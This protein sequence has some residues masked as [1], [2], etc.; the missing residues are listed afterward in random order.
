M[1]KKVLGKWA[2]MAC[3]MLMVTSCQSDSL[4]HL[5]TNKTQAAQ[6]YNVSGTE[7][8]GNPEG[9]VTLVVISSYECHYCRKDYPIIKQFVAEHPSIKLIYKS[10]LAFGLDTLVEPQYAALAAAKQHQFAA[11]HEALF[12]SN[13]PLNDALIMRLVKTLHMNKKQFTKDMHS[14][15]VSQQVVSN[16]ELIDQL[17]I[18]GI[19]TVIMAPTAALKNNQ[20]T[21]YIQVGF[22]T[23]DV[24]TDM[25]TAVNKEV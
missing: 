14:E 20:L 12:T 21:Q 8:L 15:Q 9:N 6:L 3:M 22:I 7:A 1:I 13:E 23:P 5:T 4:E 25:L 10:Y 18:Q 16:T 2:F 17:G 19:P 11:M 24:L